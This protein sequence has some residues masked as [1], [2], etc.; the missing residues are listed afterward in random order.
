MPDTSPWLTLL[1]SIGVPVL[2]LLIWTLLIRTFPEVLG[3]ALVKRI[4]FGYDARLEET[5][6]KNQE[7]LAAGTSSVEFLSSMQS[8]LRMKTIGSAEILW[9]AI[10]SLKDEFSDIVYHLTILY[11][12]EINSFFH[13]NDRGPL[14]RLENYRDF[15]YTT[16]KIERV[17]SQPVEETRLF[18]GDRLWYL[19]SATR[20][21]YGRLG[22][23]MHLSF[24]NSEYCDWRKDDFI[25]SQ[26]RPLLDSAAI[27]DARQDP[28]GGVQILVSHLES[29]FLREATRVMSGSQGLADSLS[30]V[31]AT[32]AYGAQMTRQMQENRIESE[33][34]KSGD[35][36]L[37]RGKNNRRQFHDP[38]ASI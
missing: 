30:D 12:E 10:L 25:L 32:L 22:Y 34:N 9:R 11:P 14:A 3:E 28:F 17:L 21:F 37:L 24:E 4:Q 23:L 27:E 20:A 13:R 1:I 35:K 36:F 31:Q 38:R 5:K 8:E 6:A 19:F 29:E 7:R 26:L 33:Q 18:V 15:Q 16:D 2:L